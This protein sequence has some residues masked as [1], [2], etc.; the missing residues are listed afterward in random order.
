MENNF[1]QMAASAGNAVAYMIGPIFKHII[2]VFH[3]W[4]HEYCPLKRQLSLA[5]PR[6]PNNIRFAADNG[7]FKNRA[8][9][10]ECSFVCVS[11]SVVL[12]G[13]N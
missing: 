8:Q 11:R 12:L 2:D 5:A 3:Q 13:P 7:I 4:L 6:W 1:I 10:I 9:N